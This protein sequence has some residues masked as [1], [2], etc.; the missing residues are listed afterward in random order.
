MSQVAV[1]FLM[2]GTLAY[3]MLP[4]YIS[5][6]DIMQRASET[7]S[8]LSYDL[9]RVASDY[10]TAPQYET[11]YDCS[12]CQEVPSAESRLLPIELITDA[13]LD[14]QEWVPSPAGI[15]LGHV[16]ALEGYRRF[17]G[18]PYAKAPAGGRRWKAAE[19]APKIPGNLLFNAKLPG[20]KC[21]QLGESSWDQVTSYLSISKSSPESEDCLNLNV[22]SPSKERLEKLQREVTVMLFLHGGQFSGGSNGSNLYDPSY[23]VRDHDVVVVVPNYRLGILGFLA[24]AE[25]QN[26][27][28]AV[29]NYGL[30]D[31]I[32][33]LEWTIENVEAFGGDPE[34]ITIAGHGSGSILANYLLVALGTGKYSHL[35]FAVKRAILFSGF[36]GGIR[37]RRLKGKDNTMFTQNIYDL[38]ADE[39][40]SLDVEDLR[41]VPVEQLTEIAK[42]F[43]WQEE[44]GPLIDGHLIPDSPASLISKGRFVHADLLISI[45]ADEGTIY[46]AKEGVKGEQD[47][48]DWM[49]RHFEEN[50]ATRLVEEYSQRMPGASPFQKAARAFRDMAYLDPAIKL[51]EAA[52]NFCTVR[53]TL[54]E[55][56][57][58]LSTL[59]SPLTHNYGAFHCSE[60][61][62]LFQGMPHVTFA[63]GS[64]SSQFQ[65]NIVKFMERGVYPE[66]FEKLC[67]LNN[68]LKPINSLTR[69]ST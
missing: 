3:A 4:E 14:Y 31:V 68:S 22:Y 28:V 43:H 63:D 40:T 69:I 66:D 44:W 57:P 65:K 18:I 2:L 33:A 16:H 37:E 5:K 29:G 7:Y 58:L 11:V 6:S 25:L 59:A 64:I 24:S 21:H 67:A 36:T 17:L 42:K 53:F 56:C 26:D 19:R 47:F 23:F 12:F 35:R 32:A 38:L 51:L 49:R 54:F 62:Q 1:Y 52:A 45:C 50:D 8:K 55:H 41:A 9:N 46:A 48:I 15:F 13:V 27:D 10:I 30:T 61:L 20:N 39:T 34:R 60:M